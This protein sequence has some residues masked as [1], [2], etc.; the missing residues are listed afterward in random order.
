[1]LTAGPHV[2]VTTKVWLG[3]AVGPREEEVQWA[4]PGSGPEGV[5]YLF[6]L[7]S[8]PSPR[9]LFKFKFLF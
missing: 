1:V 2:A 8:F 3:G 7:F 5:F 4:E 9:L 6:L